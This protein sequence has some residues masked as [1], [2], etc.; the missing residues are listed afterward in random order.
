M[1]LQTLKH[2]M[3]NKFQIQAYNSSNWFRFSL[4]RCPI[5]DFGLLL[6]GCFSV[7]SAIIPLT[8]FPSWTS[9]DNDYSTG[10]GFADINND[11]YIDFCTSNGNDMAI[12]KQGIYFNN[13][14]ILE[15]QATWRSADSG[16]FG[17]L[18]LGDINNDG[19][20]DMAVSYLGLGLANQ[21]LCRIYKNTGNGLQQTPY[22]LSSDQYNSFDVSFGDVDLDGDLD[23]AV[24]A[25]DAYNN[26][27]SPA[28]IYKN[29]NGTFES[30]AY[31]S[32]VD[33]I[34]SDAIRF[35]DLNQDGYLDLIVGGYR[36]LWVYYNQN[37]ILP[38]S[39]SWSIN[40]HGWILRIATGDYDNDGWIDVAIAVNGQLTA[41]SSYIKVFKNNQGQLYAT[42]S[43]TMLR[44]RHYCSCVAWGDINNDGFLDMAAGGWWEPLVVFE[45]HNGILDTIPSW[46]WS[47]SSNLVCEAI[48]LGDVRNYH[49]K[50]KSDTFI[51][52][53][54]RKLFYTTK[55][56][57][58]K[59]MTVE[60]QG[61]I[62][63]TNN[64]CDDPL[65]GWV[66]LNN[67]PATGETIILTYIYSTNPDLAVTNWTS[68]VGN[69][70]FYNTAPEAVTENRIANIKYQNF[71]ATPNPFVSELRFQFSS[72][73]TS[74]IKIYNA[75]GILIRTLSNTSSIW[76]GQDKFGQ[77]IQ[78]GIYFINVVIDNTV[79][80]KKIVKVSQR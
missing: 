31:W 47:G 25:G 2:L 70:L 18:Y 63:A 11:G 50:I 8:T 21:G 27:R 55:V 49:L 36:K 14:G 1:N 24:A 74:S 72:K 79:I 10:G 17:H 57:I 71:S 45:N 30:T 28:R 42:S 54:T 40:E 38:Q 56:P 26:I 53:S 16:Y 22:W 64:Y 61:N 80:T 39:A 12:N 44:N 5:S 77:E 35:A 41:D 69:Y 62:I 66:V 67:S 68:A 6:L 51:S 60:V 4:F 29:N 23:L 37:G 34:P 33:S 3:S 75:S 7:T 20:V 73:S 13:A 9:I 48:V 19:F 32:S 52:N 15:T 46:S 58:Q 59:L 78:T 76:N 43:F 65:T